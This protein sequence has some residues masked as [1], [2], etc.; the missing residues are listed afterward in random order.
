MQEFRLS[1]G[2]RTASEISGNVKSNP[3][4]QATLAFNE[5]RVL[6]GRIEAL[7]E[8]LV[9]PDPV[10]ECAGVETPQPAGYFHLLEDDADRT[11][12][13]LVK[14]NDALLRIERLVL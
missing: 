9:G 8:R 10:S 12:R 11:L 5:V 14:A 4:G 6:V 2:L 1:N 3:F 13:R 7:A